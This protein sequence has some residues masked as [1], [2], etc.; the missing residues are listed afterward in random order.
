M[1]PPRFD[2]TLAYR[3]FADSKPGN[4]CSVNDWLEAAT[5]A[6]NES[7][8]ASLALSKSDAEL[9]LD[10]AAYAARESGVR[11]NAPL[12]CYLLGRTEAAS[13]ASLAELAEL[14]RTVPAG[15]VPV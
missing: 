4:E 10:V 3:T 11:L 5:A 13:G 15:E 8:G 6:L 2:S 7:S 14:I 9:I 12:V 1:S